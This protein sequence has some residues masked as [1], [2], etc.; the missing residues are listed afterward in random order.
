MSRAHQ[1]LT[2]ESLLL[3]AAGAFAEKQAQALLD[4]AAGCPECSLLLGEAGR[5][6]A[7]EAGDETNLGVSRDDSRAL[8]PGAVIASRFRV[9]RLLGQ[10]GMGEVYAALDTELDETIALKTIRPSLASA[11]TT[12]E[13]F[14]QEARLAR[15]VVHPNVCRV[16]EFGRHDAAAAPIYFLTMELL[17]GVP[18]SRH[19][20]ER[21]RLSA[22][23]AT[24]IGLQ[25]SAGL[26]AIH[27]E[28]VLHRD[29]KTSNIMLC[30]ETGEAG[31][32]RRGQRAVLL[33]FGVAGGLSSSDVLNATRGQPGT[34]S[35]MAPE[36][37]EGQPLSTATDV[38]SLGVVLY[39]LLVGQLPF[40]RAVSRTAAL[41]NLRLEPE[42]VPGELMAAA[43]NELARLVESCL[44]RDPNQRLK[45]ARELE[46]ELAAVKREL[47]A[48]AAT[49]TKDP[50]AKP[51]RPSSLLARFGASSPWLGPK[52]GSVALFATATILAAFG[53]ARSAT[54][55]H[56]PP[57]RLGNPAVSSSGS[58]SLVAPVASST[59]QLR[60]ESPPASAPTAKSRAN[61]VRRARTPDVTATT[62]PK[63]SSS[64]SSHCS[65]PYYF[66]DEGFRVY[67]K[68]CL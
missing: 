36:Q 60:S 17:H 63:P 9:L 27:Q 41:E 18:L 42:R 55:P 39:E 57:P 62:A 2:E 32:H 53:V 5:A 8:Q 26:R 21:S 6:V 33:D 59:L 34:P 15:R 49:S 52:G 12:I 65:P 56:D 10:G 23:E 14:R 64:A 66:D 3:L 16:L 28:G 61:T 13:R 4:D 44:R 40:G 47:S 43:P 22:T 24:D 19:L 1:C 54:R 68:E 31:E 20:R 35:Y 51:A 11:Q 38:Y 30:P 48:A 29:I 58:A 67:R 7:E 25:L 46:R 50:D 37:L 45:S